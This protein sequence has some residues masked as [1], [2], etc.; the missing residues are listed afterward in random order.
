[1]LATPL[2]S[3]SLS[4]YVVIGTQTV[5]AGLPAVAVSGT[6]Y[7]LVPSANALVV[8]GTSRYLIGSQTLAPGGA[9]VTVSGT[10]ASLLAGGSSVVIAGST[11]A[12][13]ALTGSGP[14]TT[15]EVEYLIG[16]QTLSVGGIATVSISGS[17]MQ[18]SLL[19]GGSSVV[20]GG[21]TTM[22]ASMLI[23]E[24]AKS[25]EV[26]VTETGLGGIIA[27]L[28]GFA[29]RSAGA[30]N[31]NTSPSP[32]VFAPG[33]SGVSAFNGTIFTGS[34]SSISRREDTLWVAWWRLL[35]G[36]G[37]VGVVLL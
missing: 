33:A 15:S 31:T 5:S 8:D 25:T 6:T 14:T 36:L 12:L 17:T 13:S 18:V 16:S 29:T 27:S 22:P 20:I 1:M 4:S 23:S 28:G 3:P 2:P 11:L 32:Y 26:L 34:A 37:T 9:A 10:V 19:A 21:T 7:S 30:T 35:L 24:G